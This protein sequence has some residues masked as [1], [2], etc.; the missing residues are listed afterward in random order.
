MLG[1][2]RRCRPARHAAPPALLREPQGLL[3]KIKFN[4]PLADLALSAD[5]KY[6]GRR[7]KKDIPIGLQFADLNYNKPHG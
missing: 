5:E 6:T 1:R 4:L 7:R 2:L 3:K